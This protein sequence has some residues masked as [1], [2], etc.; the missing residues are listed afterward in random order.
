MKKMSSSTRSIEE[1]LGK[2]YLLLLLLLSTFA[3]GCSQNKMSDENTKTGGVLYF[4]IE[5]PFHGF[6]ISE[7][8][9]L[10]PPTA[11]LNN[12]ILELLFRM[13][14]SDNLIPVLGLS[15]TPSAD[16]TIWEI[17]L[18]Q[19]VFFTTAPRLMPMPLSTT[20]PGC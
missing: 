11:P 3:Y 5:V 15:A 12:L 7:T 8:G 4:G 16:G 13:D 17:K 18:R 2:L 6:D 1:P 20:G 14:K 19:G 10:N 9:V